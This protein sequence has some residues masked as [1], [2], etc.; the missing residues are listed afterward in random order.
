MGRNLLIKN[1]A[2]TMQATIVIPYPGTPLF[3]ECEE[4]GWLVTKDW[5]R[6]DMREPVM[7]SPIGNDN[8]MKLVQGLYSVS[9]NPE[10]L[11]RK[12]L[13][14]RDIGD[15]KYFIKAGKKV[16]GHIFD[17]NNK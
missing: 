2:Y 12:L 8:M 17:F 13:S 16:F 15:L 5:D 1:Y 9:F 6:F 14:I 11:A 3:T 4:N 10:F 7:K